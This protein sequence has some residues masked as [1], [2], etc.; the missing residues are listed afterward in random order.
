MKALQILVVEDDSLVAMLLVDTL[1]EMGHGVC[2]VE[3]TETGAV[4]AAL[5]YRPDLIIADAQLRQGNGISAID[6]ILSTGF[7]AHLFVSGDIKRI[8]A[9]KPGVVALEKPFREAELDRAI[10]RALDAAEYNRKATVELSNE[11]LQVAAQK[12]TS[13]S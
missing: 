8:L 3:A 7:V 2:G 11:R 6:E 4:A 10:Q 12:K 5:R 13:G 9:Q 1:V